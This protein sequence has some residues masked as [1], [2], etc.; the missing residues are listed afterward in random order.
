MWGV[1]VIVPKKLQEQVLN[2]LHQNHPGIARIK[3]LLA[4]VWLP[5]NVSLIIHN[6]VPM[7][8]I[9]LSN[10]HVS[11]PWLKLVRLRELYD[12]GCELQCVQHKFA[13]TVIRQKL[14]GFTA[15]I[16]STN[17]IWNQCF[18]IYWWSTSL[19]WMKCCWWYLG[20]LNPTLDLVST[21][22]LFPLISPVFPLISLLGIIPDL[23]HYMSQFHSLQIL[24]WVCIDASSEDLIHSHTWA[25]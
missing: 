6:C 23:W 18:S 2:E 8:K 5:H 13:C 9:N 10:L 7:S 21:Y 4:Y 15:P 12:L 3:T 14:F 22:R 25:S 16:M 24:Q 1:S 19:W 20:I 17:W 11:G